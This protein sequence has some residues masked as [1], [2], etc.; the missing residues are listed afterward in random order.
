MATSFISPFSR[1]EQNYNERMFNSAARNDA[2]DIER[3]VLRAQDIMEA[4]HSIRENR[5]Q[6]PQDIDPCSYM[7][8]TAETT[9]NHPIAEIHKRLAQLE[10]YGQAEFRR[11]SGDHTAL[12]T[13]I[14]YLLSQIENQNAA[15]L[16]L[17][18]I[19]DELKQ[20]GLQ[21]PEP[22]EDID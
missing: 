15:I 12:I 7:T 22:L 6:R 8:A 13:R 4:A 18:R 14:D 16:E 20:D 9:D 3:Y 10:N 5:M 17:S 21:P 2:V 19:I 1:A 11:I